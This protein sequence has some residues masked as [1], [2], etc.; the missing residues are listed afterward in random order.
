MITKIKGTLIFKSISKII[1]ETSGLGFE[2]MISAKTY[3]K[4]PATGKEI[5]IDTYMHVREDAIILVGFH[6]LEEKEVFLKLFT[7]SGVSVKIALSVLSIY[8]TGELARLIESK[9]SEMLKR[10]PGIGKKLSERII[11][12]MQGRFALNAA[13]YGVSGSMEPE[14]LAEIKEA[15]KSLGYSENEIIKAFSKI[16]AD[17]I[18]DKSIEDVLRK[19]LREV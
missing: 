19:I 16:N 6:E 13:D 17:E 9:Q 2:I 5:I 1:V 8:N 14:K 15:L 7:I 12:E 18:K 10:V 11:L 4:L 3:E